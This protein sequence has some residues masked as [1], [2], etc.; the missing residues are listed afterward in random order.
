MTVEEIREVAMLS[1]DAHYDCLEKQDKGFEEKAI[2]FKNNSENIPS[3]WELY[4]TTPLM[5][6]KFLIL[7]FKTNNKR[8]KMLSL[9]DPMFPIPPQ[10][11]N[12]RIYES[13]NK[14]P[15]E[16][17]ENNPKDK[18]YIL[19]YDD[20]KMALLIDLPDI[21]IDEFKNTRT[22]DI[23][24]LTDMKFLIL[25]I[26]KWYN[27]SGGKISLPTEISPLAGTFSE[28]ERLGQIKLLGQLPLESQRRALCD[29]FTKPFSYIWGA[30]GTGKTKFILAYAVIFYIQ[31]GYSVSILAPT[32]VALEQIMIGIISVS[33]KMNINR[34]HFE[35]VGTPSTEFLHNYSEL[36]PGYDEEKDKLM[37]T[38]TVKA[39]GY[40]LDKYINLYCK[41]P[42][43]TSHIFVDEAGYSS[44]IRGLTLFNHKVPIT[45]LGDHK[46]L[47]P[48][49]EADED[50]IFISSP[51]D[52]EQ[53]TTNSSFLWTF[54]CIYIE[55]LFEPEYSFENLS[56]IFNTK[57]DPFKL[58][59]LNHISI[60]SLQ[61]T[62]RFSD[63]IAKMLDKHIYE[64]GFCSKNPD[65]HT[66]IFYIDSPRIENKLEHFSKSGK[67]IEENF[68]ESEVNNVL[69][70]CQRLNKMNKDY[71]VLTPYTIQR[72][73]IQ[74]RFKGKLPE[75]KVMTIHKSQGSEYN[76]VVFSVTNKT[77]KPFVNSKLRMGQCV[78]NT[79]ISRAKEELIIV[80]DVACWKAK[81]GQ[82]ISE[83]LDNAIEYPMKEG[84]F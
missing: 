6:I 80:C 46:Q 7:H 74:K 82:L 25:R 67:K 41:S 50:K 79:A 3:R 1:C 72:D 71:I 65:S 66:N 2:S 38:F 75:H 49:T 69:K 54:P 20:R 27:D 55:K 48:F 23:E 68:S 12:N 11:Y 31:R 17:I 64:F 18:T 77:T 28:I 13:R 9:F 61:H 37:Q 83:L 70:I 19:H 57:K 44:I 5:D 58:D 22:E 40:T 16:G 34:M 8:I 10:E 78:I 21:L 73:E 76:T 39:K 30:P 15:E 56:K 81:K 35:R 43:P 42:M 52:K 51:N 63:K 59:E 53:T 47:P 84:L 24:V 26:H 4:M 32:H 62:Y 45:F 60:I 29:I 33:D 36:C 14:P